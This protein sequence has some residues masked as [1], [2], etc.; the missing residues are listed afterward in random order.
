MAALL[1][2]AACPACRASACGGSGRVVAAATLAAAT[3]ARAPA[4]FTADRE[5]TT[6]V[7]RK[8]RRRGRTAPTKMSGTAP[9]KKWPHA[10]VVA[11]LLAG[12]AETFDEQR[13]R[14][15]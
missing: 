5:H 15:E 6:A 1:L 7:P 11:L 13:R 2:A 3:A 4:S 14:Q 9:A 12:A 8:E 10:A